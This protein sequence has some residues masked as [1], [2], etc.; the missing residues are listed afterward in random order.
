MLDVSAINVLVNLD[1]WT[2]LDFVKVGKI[3]MQ[4]MYKIVN[5]YNRTSYILII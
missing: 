2:Y 5:I 1:L 4:I 3:V